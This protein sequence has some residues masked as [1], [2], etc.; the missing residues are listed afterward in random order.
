MKSMQNSLARKRPVNL[1]I[2][3]DLVAQAKSMTNNLS[4]VVEQLLADYVMKQN[5]ARQEKL[6]RAAVAA[7]SWNA[8][9]DSSGSFADEHS[10]L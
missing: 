8:F 4:G 7:A 3:E 10:T 2:N 9:N 6:H 1:T 5:N